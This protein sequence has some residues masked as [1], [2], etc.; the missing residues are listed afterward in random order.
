MADLGTLRIRPGS[1]GTPAFFVAFH[2]SEW[3]DSVPRTWPVMSSPKVACGLPDPQQ[4]ASKQL[5][6]A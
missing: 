4:L 3:K 6:N 2:R 5:N 1:L